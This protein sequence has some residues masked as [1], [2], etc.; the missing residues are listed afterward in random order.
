L[1]VQTLC[2]LRPFCSGHKGAAVPMTN[3]A[4]LQTSTGHKDDVAA[5]S[6]S[7]KEMT[8]EVVHEIC[9]ERN[10]WT[11]PRLNTQL[12]LNYKGF[13][14]IA[15]LEDYVSVK[16][17]H[18][19]NNN[20][21]QIEGLERMS[22]LRSLHLEGNR[23][24]CIENLE[25]NLELRQLNLE[26]NA[27]TRITGLACLAKLEQVN[28]SRNCLS[29]LQVLE[30][31]RPLSKLTNVDVSHNLFEESEG[32]VER[33]AEIC[34][35]IRLLRYFGNP[36]VRSVEHYR[37][38]LINALPQ[39]SYLDE[40]PVFPIER[41]SSMAWAE[42]GLEAM[43]KAKR[44][45]N[46]ERNRIQ[47]GVD[48]ERSELLT[49]MRK[50]AIERIDQEERERAALE[51]ARLAEAA[52]SAVAHQQTSSSSESQAKAGVP[53]GDAAALDDYANS[54][55]TKVKLYGADG[56]R[57]RMCK[58]EGTSTLT[59]ADRGLG[60]ARDAD[61]AA[62]EPRHHHRFQ[63][64][65]RR[66]G[67]ASAEQPESQSR[68][69]HVAATDGRAAGLCRTADVSSFLAVRSVPADSDAAERQFSVLGEEVCVR[70]SDS[71][72]EETTCPSRPSMGYA[73]AAGPGLQGRQ[74]AVMPLIWE[75]NLSSC[76]AEEMRCMEENLSLSKLQ[77]EH[78]E[79]NALD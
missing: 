43:H 44:D 8:P 22:A 30:A 31:L 79:L 37:K 65:E 73:S 70:T 64:P 51:E 36:G 41:K 69:P 39:L 19:G 55:R 5:T 38:R 4:R 61:A 56:L 60:C 48:P 25:Y 67:E 76:A 42:G 26:S 49:R 66:R 28:L 72:S 33:W 6:S 58:E 7:S 14:S 45:Y 16:T 1:T 68:H 10:M 75:Q 46:N 63:P 77:R 59:S 57:E 23:L 71:P 34:P 35:Q 29:D 20:I 54:W 50:R 21:K 27:L 52:A 24:S 2:V 17:L 11:Q 12:Y 15:G 47:F 78:H 40:R 13:E 53:A 3:A 9:K 62:T 32:V 18:L 74:Q